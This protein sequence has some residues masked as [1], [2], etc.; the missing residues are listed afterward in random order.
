[1]TANEW[2]AIIVGVFSIIGGFTIFIKWLVKHF[3]YELKPN[4]GNSLKDQVNRLEGRVD[5]I[6]RLLFERNSK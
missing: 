4:G 3:L 5:D 2:V 1:M 6:Y